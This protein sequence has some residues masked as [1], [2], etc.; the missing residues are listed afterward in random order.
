VIYLFTILAAALALN[1]AQ[2]EIQIKQSWTF[3]NEQITKVEFD[4]E[5]KIEHMRTKN[6]N[7]VIYPKVTVTKKA[8]GE[9][10]QDQTIV[11][12]TI[13]EAQQ[14]PTKRSPFKLKLRYTKDEVKQKVESI[15]RNEGIR[16]HKTKQ[17]ILS[18]WVIKR[19]K[20]VIACHSKLP[21][22]EKKGGTM[23]VKMDKTAKMVKSTIHNRDFTTCVVNVFNDAP[24][25][26]VLRMKFE[27]QQVNFIVRDGKE[28]PVIP[29]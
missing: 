3:K 16:A 17:D 1:T 10:Q 7:I 14:T 4:Q 22:R 25:I 2:I 26:G 23:S 9:G 19:W 29:F 13:Y 27:V 12:R 18:P 5:P 21:E 28:I 24:Q 20:N 11:Y 15:V 6:S 8:E